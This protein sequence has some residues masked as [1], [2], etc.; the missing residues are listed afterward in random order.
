MMLEEVFEYVDLLDLVSQKMY[1]WL[2]RVSR[3]LRMLNFSGRHFTVSCGGVTITFRPS[4]T[5]SDVS[6]CGVSL[7]E[8][9]T[10]PDDY[11]DII[12][13]FA[14]NFECIKRAVEEALVGYG[15][16]DFMKGVRRDKEVCRKFIESFD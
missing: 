12:I 14:E 9:Y 16:E 1:M 15:L 4:H 3:V 11:R 7:Q 6:V 5:V 13:G 2:K 8:L 10:H